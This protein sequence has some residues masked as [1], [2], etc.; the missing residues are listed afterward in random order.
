M[1]PTS[2]P[3]PL[4][5]P[6]S[7][8]LKLEVLRVTTEL[9]LDTEPIDTLLRSLSESLADI[10]SEVVPRLLQLFESDDELSRID[11]SPTLRA[12]E[13][14]FTLQPT[15]RFR[16]LVAAIRAGDLNALGIGH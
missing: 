7:L 1:A 15:D 16:E 6:P 3:E 10:P 5:R 14:R 2:Q 12:G 9:V 8:I 11:A 4:G 13:L